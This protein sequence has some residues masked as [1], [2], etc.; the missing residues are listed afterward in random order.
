MLAK[1][2]PLEYKNKIIEEEES[3]C[4]P[5]LGN[6]MLTMLNISP[7]NFEKLE[8]KLQRNNSYCHTLTWCVKKNINTNKL[9]SAALIVATIAFAA[10]F[11]F[12]DRT[13]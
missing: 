13:H 2:I 4:L 11:L 9:N 3:R 12:L 8:S 5:K 1:A 6:C 10:S 7:R